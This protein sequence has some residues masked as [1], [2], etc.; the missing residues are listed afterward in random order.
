MIGKKLKFYE[1]ICGETWNEEIS[2]PV[3]LWLF[4]AGVYLCCVWIQDFPDIGESDPEKIRVD[5]GI[6]FG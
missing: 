6:Y 1:E 3:D 4:L 2:Y 5:W